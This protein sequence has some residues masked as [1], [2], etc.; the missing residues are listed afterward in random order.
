MSPDP[1][2]DLL[3]LTRWLSPAFPLGSFA[4][5]SGME[6]EIAAGRLHDGASVR[7]WLAQVLAHGGLRCDAILLV[8]ARQ[9][10]GGVAELARALAPTA[11][12]WEETRAQGT[13]FADTVTALDGAALAPAALPVAVGMASARLTGLGDAQV[14]A[15]Y[16]QAAL[17]TL[18]S[19]AVRFVPLGQT[20]GQRI[21]QALAPAAQDVARE[22]AAATLDDIGSAALGADLASAEH[23]TLEVRIF[24]S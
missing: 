7:D 19:A 10:Q 8:A 1:G 23:E 14:A 11:E 17:S 24:R 9:G 18:I 4:Y 3:T 22:A 21:L 2:A 13:A 20:E 15:H 12:R 5:S 6:T 16:L